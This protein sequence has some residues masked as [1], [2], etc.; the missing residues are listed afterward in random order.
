MTNLR[1][2]QW[3]NLMDKSVALQEKILEEISIL[4]QIDDPCSTAFDTQLNVIKK[5]MQMLV[6]LNSAIKLGLSIQFKP[7][8]T[9]EAEE[10]TQLTIENTEA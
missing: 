3:D 2:E 8:H 4:E 1:P 5:K 7:Q 6:D 9:E 10:D